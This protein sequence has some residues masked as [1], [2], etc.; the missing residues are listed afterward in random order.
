MKKIV[1]K[2]WG[3]NLLI[4]IVL[5]VIYRI[6]ISKSDTTSENWLD[7]ILNILTLLLQLE[8]ALINLIAMICCSLAILL[9]LVKNI[10]EMFIF[11]LLSFIGLP[12]I[13]ICKVGFH[14]SQIYSSDT[15]L[16]S[17]LTT[18]LIIVVVY[19]FLT[20]VQ[21]LFFRKK[22]SKLDNKNPA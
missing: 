5:F 11:S 10:R 22:M 9:N 13:Y 7:S 2:Y 17:Q 1:F 15:I 8:F 21:F 3:I 4:G 16:N 19:L 20:A 14:I 12:I 6:V 18:V